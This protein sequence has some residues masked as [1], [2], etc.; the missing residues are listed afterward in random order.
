MSHVG[1]DHEPITA[2]TFPS[3]FCDVNVPSHHGLTVPVR[4]SKTIVESGRALRSGCR[5]SFSWRVPSPAV[6]ATRQGTSFPP[7]QEA[8][9]MERMLTAFWDDD[10]QEV[11]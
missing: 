3:L 4:F 9:A 11:Q 8:V 1:C 10:R 6:T 5:R 7:G 2:Q